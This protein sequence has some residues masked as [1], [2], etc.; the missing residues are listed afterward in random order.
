MFK[1][2]SLNIRHIIHMCYMLNVQKKLRELR[3]LDLFNCE[4]TNGETYREKVFEIID[5][6]CYLDGFDRD[7]KEAE[8]DDED[9]DDVEGEVSGESDDEGLFQSHPR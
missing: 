4:V 8:D 6:L 5:S 1:N 2:A 3:N 9:G 7:D